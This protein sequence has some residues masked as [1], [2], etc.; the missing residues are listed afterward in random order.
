MGRVSDAKPRLLQA[1][2]D[3]IWTRSYGAV[4]VD[5][6]CERAGVKKGSFYYFFTSKDELVAAAMDT[7]WDD[8]RPVYDKIFSASKPPL[9]RLRDWFDYVYQS[10]KDLRGQH[11]CI[12][13]RPWR[14]RRVELHV[15][16]HLPESV[17]WVADQTV[18]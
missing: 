18:R 13:L 6:I 5:D 2:M 11:G 1:A 14:R 10:Q 12:H 16:D 4:S 9:D 8:T 7:K 3:L 17:R 15:E